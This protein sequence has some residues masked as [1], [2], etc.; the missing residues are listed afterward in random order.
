MYYHIEIE[1]WDEEFEL[2]DETKTLEEAIKIAMKVDRRRYKAIM[3]YKIDYDG[4]II[5]EMEVEI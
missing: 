1:T 3:I 5:Q 2:I 4:T